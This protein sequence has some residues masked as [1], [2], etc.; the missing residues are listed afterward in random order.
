MRGNAGLLARLELRHAR[1]DLRFLLFAAGAD[2][3]EDRGFLERAYQLY[4]AVLFA[5]ALALSWAQV[6]DIVAGAREALGALAGSIAVALLAFLPAVLLVCWTISGL[7]E[8][9]LR[10]TLPDISWLARVV[11]PEE[12]LA[13]RLV[14]VVALWLLAGALGGHALGVL[15]GAYEPLAWAALLSVLALTARLASLVCA[16]VRSSARRKRRL[17]LT[18]ASGLVAV[19]L[20]TLLALVTPTLVFLMGMLLVPLALVVDVVLVAIALALAAHADMAFVVDDNELYAARKSLSFLAFVNAGAYKEACRRRRFGRRRKARRTWRFARGGAAHVS[21]ALL[22]LVRR[23]SL[24]LGAL[25]WGGVLVPIGILLIAEG[26]NLGVLLVWFLSVALALRE[27]LPL[28]HVFREDCANRLVRPLL[29]TGA[30]SLL[31]LDS[32]PMLV[33]SLASS[34][35]ALAVSV[36]ALGANPVPSALLAWAM[37]LM[38]VLAAAFDDPQRVRSVGA[39]RLTAFS[40]GVLCVFVVGLV[41]L[42]G[43]IPALACAVAVDLILIRSLR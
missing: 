32:L 18:V 29:P 27:P 36:G 19:L 22:S 21:H 1:S 4:L 34:A 11:R 3:D 39:F 41:G 6:V 7:Q 40:C 13:V 16:L 38:L 35:L 10:L 5:F 9:P 30:L 28:A 15:A 24:L 37:L 33:V 2:I 42:L 43:V 12:I 20:A 26:A 25:T 8:T 31:L 23:P 17:P 14:R